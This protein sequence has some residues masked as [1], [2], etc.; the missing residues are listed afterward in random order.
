MVV[1]LWLLI[2]DLLLVESDLATRVFRPQVKGNLVSTKRVGTPQVLGNYADHLLHLSSQETAKEYQ[3]DALKYLLITEKSI[4]FYYSP[5]PQQAKKDSDM[6]RLLFQKLISK[7]ESYNQDMVASDAAEGI[8]LVYVMPCIGFVGKV[9]PC[10]VIRSKAS[11]FS[12]CYVAA[13]MHSRRNIAETGL[14]LLLE[15]LKK[16]QGAEF[17]N[18]FY[19]TYFST[20][21][22]EIFAVLTDAFH[23]YM[24]HET[25]TPLESRAEQ[26]C[27]Q[28]FRRYNKDQNE[29]L[30]DSMRYFIEAAEVHSSID[31]GNKTREDCAQASLL[32]LQ[33]RM[34][35]SQWLDGKHVVVGVTLAGL[36]CSA[37]VNKIKLCIR[38]VTTAKSKVENAT[39]FRDD[40][41]E[42]H[43]RNFTES[44]TTTKTQDRATARSFIGRRVSCSFRSLK[45]SSAMCLSNNAS[46][47]STEA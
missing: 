36:E 16:F 38:P 39:P 45:V 13:I 27:E 33:I 14:N 29:D 23:K 47:S 21:E 18:Q 8:T 37:C 42:D 46:L 43:C 15:M 44:E 40:N 30:L 7:I 3:Q 31:A 22:N 10:S 4:G 12:F 5:Q 9:K 28:W 6:A 35:D 1:N 2:E 26:S 34:P 25:A 17:C 32:S 20:T 24:K 19:R 41:N 11:F